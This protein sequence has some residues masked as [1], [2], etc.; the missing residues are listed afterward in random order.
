MEHYSTCSLSMNDR[1]E[2]AGVKTIRTNDKDVV[3]L[4]YNG[5]KIKRGWV[6]HCERDCLEGFGLKI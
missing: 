5:I 2:K 1:L 4:E 6:Q 3:Y